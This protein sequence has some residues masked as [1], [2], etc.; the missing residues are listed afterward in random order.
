MKLG[1]T[2]PREWNGYELQ[3]KR[4]FAWFE[5]IKDLVDEFHTGCAIGGDEAITYAISRMI[6]KSKIIGHP[7]SFRNQTSQLCLNLC[8]KVLPRKPPLDRNIDIVEAVDVLAAAPDGPEKQRSGTWFTIRQCRS[9]EK[10]LV[11]FLPD[12]ELV[13]ERWPHS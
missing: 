4:M 7:C 11:I 5:S 6:D 9:R 12:G 1:I 3:E 13:I 10:P 2:A 8:G